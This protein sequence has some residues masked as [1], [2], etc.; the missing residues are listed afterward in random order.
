MYYAN[1][2]MYGEPIGEAW[3]SYSYLQAA[4]F[5]VLVAGTIIYGKGDEKTIEREGDLGYSYLGEEAIS[6]GGDQST[7]AIDITSGRGST[8]PVVIAT[9]F[10]PS[11][12]RRNAYYD[13]S[14]AAASVGSH[15]GSLGGSLSRK[16]STIL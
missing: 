12:A 2:K 4:G 6:P 11:S 10:T 8:D 14:T 9:S 15:G 3:N 16:G 13:F 1:V 7:Q 5:A